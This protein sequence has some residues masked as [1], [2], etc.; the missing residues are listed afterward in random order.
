MTRMKSLAD[1]LP[2]DVAAKIHPE[3]RRNESD[4][5]AAREQLLSQYRDRWI[6]FADG[7]VL[8]SGTSPVEVL[9]QAQQTGR[10]PFV[11]CVGRE[12][13]PTAMRRAVFP[14]DTSYPGEPLPVLSVEFR[15]SSGSAGLMLG[16]VIPDTG[17]DASALPWSDCQRMQLD[18]A[19]GVPGLIGGVGGSATAT[20]VFPAWVRLDGADYPCRLQAEFA[21]RERLLGRDVLNRVDVLFRGPAAEVVINP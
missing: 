5:W 2:P 17:A 16:E 9:H 10:H 20:L 8:V 12:H 3:W 4:Y 19:D 18:P 7:S 15:P 14:Y 13:E 1:G 11:V 6:A 21:G